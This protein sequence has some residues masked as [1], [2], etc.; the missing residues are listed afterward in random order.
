ML[1][2][3]KSIVKGF[4]GGRIQRHVL[5]EIAEARLLERLKAI[6]TKYTKHS[7]AGLFPGGR[8]RSIKAGCKK[9]GFN[10]R[11]CV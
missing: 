7:K 1:R 4:G 3:G 11:R 8:T 2:A 5:G 9:E 10:G 6:A